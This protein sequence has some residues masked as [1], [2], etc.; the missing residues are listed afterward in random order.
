[1]V[2]RRC[3]RRADLRNEG[4][5]FQNYT[6]LFLSI[7]LSSHSLIHYPPHTHTS[8]IFCHTPCSSWLATLLAAKS[9]PWK[10]PLSSTANLKKIPWTLYFCP[11]KRGRWR[12]KGSKEFPLCHRN[13]IHTNTK[14]TNTHARI[15]THIL[16]L[17][18]TS[19]DIHR[20]DGLLLK[21]EVHFRNDDF[22]IHSRR[23]HKI[24]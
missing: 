10:M 21:G 20:L 19:T 16:T 13:I 6:T 2:S 18:C 23:T 5:N 17:T 22:P 1:M 12:E 11:P 4:L 8:S 9:S 24:L 7:H 15:Q 14:R 3:N